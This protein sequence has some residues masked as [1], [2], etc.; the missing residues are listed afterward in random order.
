V[1]IYELAKGTICRVTGIELELEVLAQLASSTR[2]RPTEPAEVTFQVHR[3]DE[4][5]ILV[6]PAAFSIS[7][8]TEVEVVP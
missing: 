7:R 8:M 5:R 4:V 2:V 1:K 6:R 3:G